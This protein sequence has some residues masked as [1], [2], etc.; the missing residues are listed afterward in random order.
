MVATLITFM[1]EDHETLS[2]PPSPPANAME[3]QKVAL[4][5]QMQAEEAQKQAIAMQAE[6]SGLPAPLTAE[7]RLK[8]ASDA[9][10]AANENLINHARK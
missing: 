5:A 2:S 6:E 7:E 4:A 10:L 8:A 1:N 3:A 9:V